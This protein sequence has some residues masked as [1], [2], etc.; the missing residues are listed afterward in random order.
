MPDYCATTDLQKVFVDIGNYDRKLN[1]SRNDWT[2]YSD[3]VDMQQDTGGVV[4]LYRDGVDLGTAEANVGACDADGKWYYKDGVDSEILYCFNTN[5]ADTY[6]WQS[7]PT[8]WHTAQNNAIT[9]ASEQLETELDNRIQRPIP[10]SNRTGGG[11]YDYVIVKAT[12]LLACILLVEASDPGASVL[13]DLRNQLYGDDGII[14][15]INSGDLRLS[16]EWTRSDGGFVE[17]GAI[18]ATTTGRPIDA[19]GSPTVAYNRYKIK[20]GTGGTVTAGSDNTTVTFGVTD[21]EGTSVLGDTVIDQSGYHGIGGG[22]SVRF[23]PGV[24]VADDYWWLTVTGVAPSTNV[25]QEIKTVR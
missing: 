1:L 6:T 20:I 11:T 5:A 8:D 25:I 22:Y 23:I 12:A 3:D 14:T 18:D 19:V 16:F 4:K 10:Q 17:E 15:R 9:K 2:V 7:A 21:I 13:A 24:Y